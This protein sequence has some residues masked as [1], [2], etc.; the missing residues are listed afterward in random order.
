LHKAKRLDSY[1]PLFYHDAVFI[2]TTK[3]GRTC[4]F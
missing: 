3:L 1:S 2:H 4:S